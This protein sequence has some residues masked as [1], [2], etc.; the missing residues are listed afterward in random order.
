MT[1]IPFA[2]SLFC[3]CAAL[4]GCAATAPDWESRFGDAAR[5]ARAT[6]VIDP[7][8]SS[9]NTTGPVIDSKATAGAQTNYATSYGYAVKEVKA[10]AI[11][12][13]PGQ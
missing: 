5:Q 4:A 11:T 1:P 3:A 13:V 10:P 9:R 2:L 12:L 8:A 7:G 6:Q